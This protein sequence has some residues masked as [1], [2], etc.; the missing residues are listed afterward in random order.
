MNANRPRLGFLALLAALSLA[1]SACGSAD[2]SAI[3]TVGAATLSQADFEA[4]LEA[5]GVED[6]SVVS[7]ELSSRH[8][9]EWIF[10]ESWIDLAAEAGTDLNGLH[11][12]LA[13][14]ELEPRPVTH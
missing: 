1:A 5:N 2:D 11:L 4:I 14:V 9:S 13:R 12:D 3:A 8:L 10:F 6:T 7:S